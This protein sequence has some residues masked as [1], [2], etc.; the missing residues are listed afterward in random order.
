MIIAII[1]AVATPVVAGTASFDDDFENATLRV[2]FYQY[3]DKAAQFMAIHRLIRQ[4]EW[5]GPV[6]HLI[7]PLPYGIY[8]ARLTDKNDGRVLY[9]QG[10]DSFF[11]EY[12]TTSPA[13]RGIVR[14]FNESVLVPFPRRA[15]I[16]SLGER[17]P[18]GEERTLVEV[19]VDPTSVDIAHDKPASGA[20]VVQSHVAGDPHHCLDI[21]FIGEGYTA[22]EI[23][24][25]T[26]DVQRFTELMLSQEPYASRSDRINI[27]GVLL[28]SAES[29]VDEPTRGVWRSTSIGASFNSFS[30][31]RYLLTDD[32]RALR[33]IA[34]T[35]PYDTLLIMVNHERYG[36][37]G[38]YN[39]FCT[40]TAHGPVSGYLLLHEFGH[41]FGGLADEYYTSSTA[42]DNF[43]PE[44]HEPSAPNITAEVDPAKIKWADLLTEGVE[45]PVAWDK[46]AYDEADLAYQAQ[47]RELNNAIAEAARSGAPTAEIEA[48]EKAEIEHSLKRMAEVEAFMEAGGQSDLVAAFEGAGY[49]SEGLYRP[50]IDCIMFSRGVKPYCSVCRRAVNAR[51]NVY[52]G[53]PIP[54]AMVSVQ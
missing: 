23:D 30:S 48:L 43:Y 37:G 25:F 26:A 33:D 6:R 40:F 35:V 38:L 46:G 13:G 42:Y 1:L 51:I 12:R 29:G 17:P 8:V 27:R 52:T 16:F 39:R 14:V 53:D 18:G 34:A 22:A 11:G 36:G 45:L 54:A 5:A 32:S 49:I 10:F 9:E 24:T 47:R 3:G 2:D 44:G 31:P 20:V 28:P 19:E 21:A 7:D 50:Q 41:S 4:G 15:A